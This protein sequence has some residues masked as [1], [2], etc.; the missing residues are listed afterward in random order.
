MSVVHSASVSVG[1]GDDVLLT[2]SNF[3]I[4]AMSDLDMSR[5]ISAGLCAADV[6]IW[7]VFQ[8]T[9]WAGAEQIVMERRQPRSDVGLEC[10]CKEM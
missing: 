4:C 9:S 5:A 10:I 2:R 6:A 7:F 3:A 8:M 1:W